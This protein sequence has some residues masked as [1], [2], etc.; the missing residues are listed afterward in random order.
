[1]SIYATI[2]DDVI[3][4]LK[5]SGGPMDRQALSEHCPTA[6]DAQQVSVALSQLRKHGVV[7]RQ[8]DG[9]VLVDQIV[10]Q[11]T[12]TLSRED[13]AREIDSAPAAPRPKPTPKPAPEYSENIP[14]FGETSAP[15]LVEG[16]VDPL[17]E[18]IRHMQPRTIPEARR[19]AR[20]LRELADWPAMDHEIAQYLCE[21][22]ADLERLAA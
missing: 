3:A 17:I 2:R 14:S 7:E 5:A 21:I 15:A 19:K 16:G 22:A 18:R 1:M 4:A 10:D 11:V 13:A 9:W 12:A 6:V 8:D 20:V